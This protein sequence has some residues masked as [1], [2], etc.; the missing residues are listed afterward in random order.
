MGRE[1]MKILVSACILGVNCRYDGGNSR[2]ENAI[3]RLMNSYRSVQKKQ[4]DFPH[5]V[6]PLIVGGDG[7]DVLDGKA[8][9]MTVDGEDK[10]EEFLK[11]A[12]HA[13]ELSQG[14]TLFSKPRVHLVGVGS[15]GTSQGMNCAT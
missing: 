15:T 5:R 10:T 1:V 6:P 13:L 3:N 4:A 7:N 8:K 14:A 11:G 2:D 9:V 12:R